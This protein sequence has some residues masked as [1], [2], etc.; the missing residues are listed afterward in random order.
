MAALT[1]AEAGNIQY[2][3]YQSPTK[4]N[5]LMRQEM[6]RNAQALEDHKG[7]PHIKASFEKRQKQG[8]TTEILPWKR[9]PG[10]VKR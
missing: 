10:G 7:T 9:V 3:P 8:W 6:W 5:Q 1:G 4:K 2:D